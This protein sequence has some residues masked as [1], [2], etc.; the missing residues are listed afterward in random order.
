M[1]ENHRRRSLHSF[2]RP[3]TDT[4]LANDFLPLLPFPTSSV[5]S[6]AASVDAACSYTE[7]AGE[8]GSL[9][10]SAMTMFSEGESILRTPRCQHAAAALG[11][12]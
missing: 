7:F 2:S 4:L 9:G 8:N 12:I 5:A 3:L 11:N 6:S 10:S 1:T